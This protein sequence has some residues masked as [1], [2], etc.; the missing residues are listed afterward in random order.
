[1]DEAAQQRSRRR[2]IASCIRCVKPSKG[3]ARDVCAYCLTYRCYATRQY[4]DAEILSW[5]TCRPDELA[6]WAAQPDA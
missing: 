3:A 6:R 5:L 2:R 4:T 1:L